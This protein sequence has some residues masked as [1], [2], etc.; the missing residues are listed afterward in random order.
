MGRQAG[1]SAAE[2]LRQKVVEYFSRHRLSEFKVHDH[3]IKSWEGTEAS[4]KPGCYAIS[5]EG[6]NLL[7]YIGK[8]SLGAT[9]GSRLV[10]FRY[11]PPTWLPVPAFVQVVEVSEAFE[12]PSLEEFLIRELQPKF[13]DRGI[14]RPP[15]MLGAS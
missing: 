8:A 2:A 5:P 4:Y 9:V 15:R 7:Y 1:S 11:K 14:R 10:R 3:D 12:A 6:G 13:N